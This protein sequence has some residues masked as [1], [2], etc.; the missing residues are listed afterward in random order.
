MTDTI[1]RD[2]IKWTPHVRVDQWSAEQVA[3]TARRTGIAVPLIRRPHL[4]R[5][6]K[7]PESVAE[8]AGNVLCTSGLDQITKLLTATGG[9]Q[10]LTA[11]R[12]GVGVGSTATAAAAADT[13][14]GAD[15]TAANGTVGAWYQVVDSAPTQANGVLTV[16]STFTAI[17]NNAMTWAEWCIFTATAAITA[18][19][20]KSGI[21]GF[22]IWDHK[23]PAALGTK[24]AGAVWVFTGTLT[25]S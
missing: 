22:S 12:T 10:A 4:E 7:R 15:G 9:A 5:L 23:A 6:L 17:S 25:L 13:Q 8:C 20:V 16:V 24:V 19:D 11:T 18:A 21:T 2:S 14:L 3:Y 1:A